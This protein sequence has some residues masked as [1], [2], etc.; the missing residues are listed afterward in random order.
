MSTHKADCICIECEDGRLANDAVNHPAH[1]TFGR[2]EVIEAIEDWGLGY[3]LGNAVKY[4][5]RAG[6]KDAS[7]TLEDLRKAQWYLSRKIEQI[8]GSTQHGR[9]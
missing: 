2:I 3:H 4:I 7:K 6:R 5:A 1:Y 8:A 9:R